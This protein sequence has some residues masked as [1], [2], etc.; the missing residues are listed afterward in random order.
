MIKSTK[1]E[2]LKDIAE[3]I[4]GRKIT[5]KD[6][7]V[8]KMSVPHEGIKIR[9]IDG[10]QLKSEIEKFIGMDL[11]GLEIGVVLAKDLT[12]NTKPLDTKPPKRKFN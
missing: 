4:L 3:G 10:S 5:D 7:A 12:L 6:V 1:A 11:K 9:E 2:E 8:V